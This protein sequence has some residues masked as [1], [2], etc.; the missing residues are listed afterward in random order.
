MCEL[1]EFLAYSEEPVERAARVERVKLEYLIGM[2]KE[3]AEFLSFILDYYVRNGFKELA[4]DKLKDFIAIRY[5]SMS[6]AKRLLQMN[7]QDIRAQFI[8][9]QEQLY[10]DMS[11]FTPKYKADEYK[12]SSPKVVSSMLDN[13]DIFQPTI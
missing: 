4:M 13:L 1:N 8:A 5:N 12:D 6:D 2:Q 11:G 9:L 3:Q 7:A 10:R